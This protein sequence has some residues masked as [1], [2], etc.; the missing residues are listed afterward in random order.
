MPRRI[1]FSFNLGLPTCVGLHPADGRI[2][3]YQATNQRC[4]DIQAGRRSQIEYAEAAAVRRA[5]ESEAFPFHH[6]QPG[7]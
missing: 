4:E 6:R 5:N 7:T 1:R 2:R 3:F